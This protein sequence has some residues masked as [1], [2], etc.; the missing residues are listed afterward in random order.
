MAFEKSPADFMRSLS[1][2]Y[3]KL[4]SEMITQFISVSSTQFLRGFL[5]ERDLRQFFNK[6]AAILMTNE[7]RTWVA[8]KL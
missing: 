6:N 4:S 8:C 5:S 1:F 7:M 2:F 3:K